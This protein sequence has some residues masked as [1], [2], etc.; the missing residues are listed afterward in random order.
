ML[1]SPQDFLD[2]PGPDI[3]FEKLQGNLVAQGTVG[4]SQPSGGFLLASPN[5]RGLR[6]KTGKPEQPI[7]L[8]STKLALFLAARD[9]SL[10]Q[11]QGRCRLP[12]SEPE[13]HH[14][15]FERRVGQSCAHGLP[16]LIQIRDLALKNLS[17]SERLDDVRCT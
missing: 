16:Q 17:T 14:H 6:A 10:R 4:S 15:R 13:F 5:I 3:A 2:L 9:G 11:M 1:N 7:R 8:V 12:T